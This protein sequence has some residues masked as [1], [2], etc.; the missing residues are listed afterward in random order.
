MQTLLYISN[1]FHFPR[2]LQYDCSWSNTK[3]L[4]G[5]RRRKYKLQC[6]VYSYSGLASCYS[7]ERFNEH[8]IHLL[9]PCVS[10]PPNTEKKCLKKPNLFYLNYFVDFLKTFTFENATI[11]KEI[12]AKYKE[13]ITKSMRFHQSWM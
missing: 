7:C 8:I 1:D 4:P 5:P 12:V 2:K 11:F 9:H 3:R 10:K 6:F 13:F